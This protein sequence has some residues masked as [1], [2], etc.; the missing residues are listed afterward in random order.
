[1]KAKGSLD[2]GGVRGRI[3][4]K[5]EETA[6]SYGMQYHGCGRAVLRGMREYSG[7]RID[8]S[9]LRAVAPLSEGV[10]G[11]SYSCGAFV[12]GVLAI[13]LCY[14][15]YTTE[16]SH[17]PVLRDIARFRE[18]FIREFG[19]TLCRDIQAKL[20]G[21][22]YDLTDPK[23]YDEFK[24]INP[25]EKCSKVVGKAARLAIENVMDKTEWQPPHVPV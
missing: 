4:D 7:I 22:Y 3:L 13:S 23:Q 8:D 5:V 20:L 17:E 21:K 18:A 14:G 12:A 19:S 10:A 16:S 2:D 11:D 24:A 1:M 9:L 15:P 25:Y 6:V